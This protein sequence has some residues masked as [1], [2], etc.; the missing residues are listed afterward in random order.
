MMCVGAA[1]PFAGLLAYN[2]ATTGSP[3]RLGYLAALGHLTDIGFGP[4]GLILYDRDVRPVV[5]ATDFT[6]AEAL[7]AEVASAIR[8]LAR[9]LFP[10]WGLVPLVAIAFAYR[11]RFRLAPVTAFA[12]LPLANF[13]YFGNGER[14]YLELLP[15]VLVAAAIVVRA[16]HA[17]DPGAA[18]AL[19]I[20]LVGANVVAGT[21]RVAADAWARRSRPTDSQVVARA[22]ADSLRAPG[23]LLVFEQNPPLSEPLLVGLSRFNFG[24]FPGRVV[25]ARDLGAENAQLACRLPGYRPLRAVASTAARDA[26]L[27]A[28]PGGIVAAARCDGPPLVTTPLPLE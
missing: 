21:S 24:A 26:H 7:R 18:R 15:F 28:Y 12:V 2:A 3:L 19:A 6:L 14:L 13:F 17:V 8:P 10:V 23:R 1:L 20:F 9:D 22:I 25:V 4:R 11:V 27:V 5:S 16:V